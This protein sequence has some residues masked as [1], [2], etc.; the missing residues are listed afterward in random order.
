[1]AVEALGRNPSP[2]GA[3]RL[4]IGPVP[5]RLGE[6]PPPT[7]LPLAAG[8]AA[9]PALP[10]AMSS[11]PRPPPRRAEAAR[12]GR[13]KG[14]SM[15]QY[16]RRAPS[17]R[18]WSAALDLAATILAGTAQGARRTR[19]IAVAALAISLCGCLA[20]LTAAAPASAAQAAA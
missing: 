19:R 10:L 20:V 3:L 12:R 4:T 7:R 6:M 14:E 8:A 2:L 9:P 18:I 11:G 13:P 16:C 17:I 1:M 5:G 15:R